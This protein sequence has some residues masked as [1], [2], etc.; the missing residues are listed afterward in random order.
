MP[1]APHMASAS[2][3]YGGDLQ[4]D[5][6]TLIKE[7]MGSNSREKL[8]QKERQLAAAGPVSYTRARTS[9]EIDRVL[10]AFFQQKGAHAR[11]RP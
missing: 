11:K 4:N 10:E 3:A 9:A 7:R 6:E 8:R 1:Y 2:R 5:F